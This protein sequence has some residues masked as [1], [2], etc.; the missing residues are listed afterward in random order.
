M[1]FRA[2]IIISEK[3]IKALIEERFNKS[4]QEKKVI[5]ENLFRLNE[6][7]KVLEDIKV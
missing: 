2:N 3:R 7:L 5:L 1:Q 4:E 6:R